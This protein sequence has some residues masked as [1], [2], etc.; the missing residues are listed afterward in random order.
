MQ[1][2]GL[3][4]PER[5]S[6]A[7]LK[8]NIRTNYHQSMKHCK[9]SEED[10]DWTNLV[11]KVPGNITETEVFDWVNSDIDHHLTHEEIL[12]FGNGCKK[13]L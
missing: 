6:K 9:N 10:L 12:N 7:L 3:L 8:R 1:Y 13:W 5:L 4:K 11:R 2:S